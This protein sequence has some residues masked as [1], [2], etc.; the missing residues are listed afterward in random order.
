MLHASPTSGGP[1]PRFIEWAVEA[2][3]PAAAVSEPEPWTFSHPTALRV[4][5][6]AVLAGARARQQTAQIVWDRPE[7]EHAHR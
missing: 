1:A 2:S 4:S 6:D 3:R 7:V 5:G